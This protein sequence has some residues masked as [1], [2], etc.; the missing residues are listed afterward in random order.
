[1]K[2]ISVD[3]SFSEPEHLIETVLRPGDDFLIEFD[4]LRRM[5]IA[6][7]LQ[8]VLELSHFHVSAHYAGSNQIDFVIRL[9]T[10]SISSPTF[11]D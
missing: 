6:Q 11:G 7:G 5:W 8:N 1:M 10:D 3:D 9:G 2:A 4:Y